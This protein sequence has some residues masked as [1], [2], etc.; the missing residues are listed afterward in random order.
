MPG[1]LPPERTGDRQWRAHGEAVKSE[2]FIVMISEYRKICK[3]R[4]FGTPVQRTE[5]RSL[6]PGDRVG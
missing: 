3:M 6:R 2:L 4:G 5:R 1:D